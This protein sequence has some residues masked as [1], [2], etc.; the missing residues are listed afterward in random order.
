LAEAAASVRI[1]RGLGARLQYLLGALAID[2]SA[3][4]CGD[5]RGRDDDRAL[6]VGERARRA[7]AAGDQRALDRRRRA[8]RL[9]QRDQAS[10]TFSS[11]IAVAT[12]TAD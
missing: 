2:R 3:H 6:L 10:P 1:G 11:V 7:S 9:E 5:R 12:S 4:I 8:V